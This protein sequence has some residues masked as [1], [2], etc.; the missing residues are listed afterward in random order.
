MRSKGRAHF[1]G[2]T[3]VRES[4]RRKGLQAWAKGTPRCTSNLDPGAA[5]VAT[6]LRPLAFRLSASSRRAV[7]V[8]PREALVAVVAHLALDPQ[9]DLVPVSLRIQ[10]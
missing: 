5:P 7:E 10:N 8:A 3:D 4:F 1:H 6:C 9:P 2:S